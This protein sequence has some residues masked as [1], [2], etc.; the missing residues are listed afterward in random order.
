MSPVYDVE[1]LTPSLLAKV[2]MNIFID[3]NIL[4]DLYHLSGPDLDELKKIIK[5]HQT[6]QIKIYLPM[7][8]KDEFYRN[9]ERV[10]KESIELFEKSKAS[11]SLPNMAKTHDRVPELRSLQ[12]TFNQMVRDIKADVTLQAVENRLKADELIEVLFDQFKDEALDQ[13]IIVKAK[14]R[15]QIGNPPGKKDSLGDAINWEWLI[16]SVPDS[17]DLNIVSGDGDFE[18][19][20]TSGIV[21]DFLKREWQ[22]IKRSE[23]RL[24][25]GL[26]E[27]LK[28]YFPDIKL[29]D[30]IDKKDAIMKLES[31][32]NFSATHAA[33]AKLNKYDEFNEN[34][35]LR[36]VNAFIENQQVNR[37]LGDEDVFEFANKLLGQIKNV[38]I[39][40]DAV[41]LEAMIAQV[42]KARIADAV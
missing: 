17:E 42:V 29:S 12:E 22:S 18:S 8:V 15:Q 14:V 32:Y 20:L 33:I 5:L 13:E 11:S 16:V 35:Q 9:R 34:E 28:E 26:P 41:P 2:R 31:S 37:I 38:A 30:D 19:V 39:Q 24:F 7:Q 23:I 25:K 40:S 6:A 3:T 21:K 27:L 1:P 4:L 10:V 36:L